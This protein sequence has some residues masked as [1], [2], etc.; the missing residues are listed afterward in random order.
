MALSRVPNVGPVYALKLLKK[1]GDPKMIFRQDRS[2][3]GELVP[4]NAL[5]GLLS[6]DPESDKSI[7]EEIEQIE[8]HDVTVITPLDKEYP[9]LLNSIFDPPT[10]LYVKGKI[11]KE[12]EL[13]VAIVGTRRPSRYG[14]E[15][16]RRF[17][18]YL[19][20][21][22][23]TVISGMAMGVDGNSQDAAI[24]AGGRTIA[25]LGSGVDIAYPSINRGLYKKIVENGAVISELPM[26]TGPAPH[27]FPRRNRIISGLSLGVFVIAGSED[28][29]ALITAE[30]A[31]D[32]GREV[33]ALPGPV[34]RKT[35]LG[36]NTLIRQ[37]A[38]PVVEPSQIVQEL[39]IPELAQD[40]RRKALDIAQGLEGRKKVIFNTLDYEPKHID[41]IAR[42]A[43][44][45]SKH[46]MVALSELE[47]EELV[48]VHPGAR[49]S[50]N[51]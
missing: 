39:G 17:A 31:A 25:V 38:T 40:V 42:E 36:P 30:F 18:E 47:L 12:D 15:Q 51:V 2:A 13:A 10:I 32:Q 49:Y 33:F 16:A 1:F 21:Q 37:G 27:N 35:S 23:I 19:V 48:K 43:A 9:K 26:G 34:D 22:G 11:V 3:L 4:R 8:K 45:D 50:K 20:K 44:M 6:Y 7:R 46:V 24:E 28:S 5:E 41:A 14:V 29:G